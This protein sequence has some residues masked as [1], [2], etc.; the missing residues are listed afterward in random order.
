MNNSQQLH[1]ETTLL[2]EGGG[3]LLNQELDL[4]DGDGVGNLD[5]KHLHQNSLSYP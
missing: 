5:D 4:E 2:D 1:G 3:L